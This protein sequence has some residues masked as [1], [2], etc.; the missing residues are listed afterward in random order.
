MRTTS[1]QRSSATRRTSVRHLGRALVAVLVLVAL[2]AV[3]GQRV[4]TFRAELDARPAGTPAQEATAA[5]ASV[6]ATTHVQVIA[7]GLKLRSGPSREASVLRELPA[8]EQLVFVAEDGG[9]YHVI[10]AA[11]LEGWVAA[12]SPYSVK[13]DL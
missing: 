13:V 5:P 6:E 4:Q 9:W 11:G 10:D 7:E 3:V 8:A 12:G 2:A 1:T